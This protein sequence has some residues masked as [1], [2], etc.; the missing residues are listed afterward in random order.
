[1][2]LYRVRRCG[3]LYLYRIKGSL[4]SHKEFGGDI[5]GLDSAMH[6]MV[7]LVTVCVVR[8]YVTI[9]VYQLVMGNG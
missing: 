3:Y 9:I 8:L 1:M 7:H 5:L 6:S 4:V 2:Y